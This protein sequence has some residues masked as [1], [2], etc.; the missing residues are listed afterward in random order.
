MHPSFPKRLVRYIQS[1]APS[2]NLNDF[3]QTT[4]A[5]NAS[6]ATDVRIAVISPSVDRQHG[7]ERAVAELLDRLS[8]HHCDTIDLYAQK[9]SDLNCKPDSAAGASN[10]A[11]IIWHRVNSFP[12]PH[13]IKFL[14][15][16][17]LNRW[18]RWRRQ[19]A[20]H[21]V[22]DIIFSPGINTLDADVILVHAVFHRIAELQRS[23]DTGGIRGLHRKLYYAL[24]CNLESRV[25][26]NPGVTLAA[27][28]QHTAAQLARYFARH[29]VTVIPNGVNA[30]HFSP[31]ALAAMRE[32]Y[33]RESQCSPRDFVLL[34]IG[35][36]WRNKGLKTLLQAVAQCLAQSPAQHSAQ[37]EDIPIRLLVVGQDEQTPFRLEAQKLGIAQRVQFFAPAHDVRMF[38]AA[39]DALVAPSLEDSFNLPVL[40]AMSCGLPVVVSPAAGVTDWLAHGTDSIVL[41][42]PENKD[43][44]AAAIRLLATNSSL[45]KAIASNGLRTAAKFSWDS[46]VNELRRLLVSAAEKSRGSPQ[47][48]V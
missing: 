39:A 36:D 21:T 26:R 37:D 18:T 40:E 22:P 10:S 12:A 24:M 5:S 25:Y 9:V 13:L 38:Y 4:P 15:W 20:T 31:P 19:R 1:C 34:L 33:R 6:E 29:D 43:E 45:R 44:L 32:R 42:D 28:S 11:K 46:H 23:R 47:T 3:S 35:N 48:S 17:L 2:N 14:A 30:D 16:L 27:V 41:E 7:T 8:T